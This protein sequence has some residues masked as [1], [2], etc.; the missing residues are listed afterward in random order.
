MF[1]VA[2]W[3]MFILDGINSVSQVASWATAQAA[4]YNAPLQTAAARLISHQICQAQRPLSE[5]SAC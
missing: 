3:A 4:Q 1:L 5:M 2:F